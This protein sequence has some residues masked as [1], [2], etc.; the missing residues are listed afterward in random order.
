MTAIRDW[1]LA[2]S[3]VVHMC[4]PSPGGGRNH[5]L[6]GDE[7]SRLATWEIEQTCPSPDAIIAAQVMGILL[8]INDPSRALHEH[9][10]DP[11]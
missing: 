10:A 4:K 3:P 2:D 11:D 7:E 5:P 1:A 9:L 8:D 6:V